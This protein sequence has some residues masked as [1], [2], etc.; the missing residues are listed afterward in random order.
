MGLITNMCLG[1]C[2]STR[3]NVNKRSWMLI[4]LCK[5]NVSKSTWHINIYLKKCIAANDLIATHVNYPATMVIMLLLWEDFLRCRVKYAIDKYYAVIIMG[6][7]VSYCMNCAWHGLL[8]STYLYALLI[9]QWRH[10]FWPLQNIVIANC[11]LERN[12]NSFV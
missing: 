9:Y 5:V 11:D 4:S 1:S 8:L 3:S 10:S 6:K 7:I 12:I 2:A